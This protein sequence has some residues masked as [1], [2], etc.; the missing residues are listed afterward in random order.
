MKKRWIFLVAPP[1][2]ALLI[3][4]CGEVVMHLWNWLAPMLFGWRQIGF[5]QA[6]GLLLLCRILFG[7]WNGGSNRSGYRRRRAEKWEAMTPEE[8]DRFRQS[9]RSRCGFGPP[10]GD[11]PNREAPSH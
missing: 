3:F 10:T 5:W 1:A 8:R 9:L 4:I 2:I 11:I 6:L 7:S